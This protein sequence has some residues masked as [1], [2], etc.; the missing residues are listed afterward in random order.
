MSLDQ[1]K[2]NK[3]NAMTTDSVTGQITYMDVSSYL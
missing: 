2:K 1:Q 3:P